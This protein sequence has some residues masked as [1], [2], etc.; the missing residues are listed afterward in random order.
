M[1]VGE[2]PDLPHLPELPG[3]GPGADMIGRACAL[4]VELAVDLQPAGWRITGAEG[5]DQRRARTMLARDLDA[6]EEV[7]G[8][9]SGPLKVQVTGPWTLAAGLERPRAGLVLGDHAA[10]KDVAQ[11]L[12]EGLAAHMA[13]VRRRVPGAELL[14]QLDEPSLP[15]V[16]AGSLPT[17]SGFSRYRPV[18]DH[19]A[20]ELLGEVV[21]R[22]VDEGA[23]P[24]VHCCAAGAPFGLLA[25]A[26]A[27]ALA[28]DLTRVG[29]SDMAPLATAVEAGVGLFVGAVPSTRP[30]KVQ[31]G[32]GAPGQ[33]DAQVARSVQAMWRGLGF[34]EE[35]AA[36]GCV[37]TPACG[38]AGADPD[39]VRTALSLSR[40]AA[41]HLADRP[42]S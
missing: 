40:K 20:V 6:L 36:R 1:V 21:Q 29:E 33:T 5:L 38:L 30:T 28:F 23:Y 42:E 8:G 7:A 25:R 15:G 39:W 27:K 13:G 17:P 9:Y 22:V 34:G 14:V 26:G 35:S 3:R 24:V 4:L 10:R 41:G 12:A 18:E 37:V 16:L 32:K 11:S 31:A 2:L 19:E